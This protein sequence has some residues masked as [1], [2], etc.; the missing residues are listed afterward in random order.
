MKTISEKW[1]KHNK[2]IDLLSTNIDDFF[3]NN[4][5]KE[6]TV[7]P[8]RYNTVVMHQEI[9]LLFSHFDVKN[10]SILEV[11]ACFGNFCRCLCERTSVES[12]TILDTI[13]MLR[14]SKTFLGV[15]NINT[16]FVESDLYTTLFDKKFDLLISNICISELPELYANDLL[17]NVLPNCKSVFIIDSAIKE[18]R[19]WLE[20]KLIKYFDESSFYNI[21]DSLSLQTNQKLFLGRKNE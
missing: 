15:C 4:Y 12:Y 2:K 20:T 18:F 14:F 16:V 21:P 8:F 17:D 11:G 9:S 10:Y 3:D 5:F 7:W 6:F 13:N 1:E 19:V